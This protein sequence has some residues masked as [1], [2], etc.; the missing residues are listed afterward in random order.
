MDPWVITPPERL[1]HVEHFKVLNPVNGLVSGTQAKG[2]LM[3]SQ[4][5]PLVLAQIW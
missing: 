4:L 2:F 1:K 5:P 3:Q